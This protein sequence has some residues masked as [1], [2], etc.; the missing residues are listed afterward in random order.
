MTVKL[1]RHEMIW[2]PLHFSEQKTEEKKYF[3]A[4]EVHNVAINEVHDISTVA[5]FPIYAD[6]KW[7]N[8]LTHKE[9]KLEKKYFRPFK[10][11]NVPVTEL[12]W[13]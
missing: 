13:Y 8:F 3:R 11:H 9:G 10:L 4:F 6:W 2:T 7:L 12:A 1:S 5:I